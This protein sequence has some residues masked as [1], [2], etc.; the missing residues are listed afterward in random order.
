MNKV[1]NAGLL[2]RLR[3]SIESTTGYQRINALFDAGSFNE[4]DCYARSGEN[5][6]E[7]ITGYGTIEGC[8]AFVFSQNRD[9]EG[10]AMSKAQASKIR[11]LY[12]LALKTGTPVI[13]IY[14]SIGGRL[15][16]G[17]DIFAAYGDVLANANELSGVVPQIS[18]V[19]GPCIGTSAMIAASADFIVMSDKGE[20]TIDTNGEKGSAD[21]AAKMG[22]C[23]ILAKDEQEAIVSV[24]KLITLLPSNNLSGIPVLEMQ[25]ISDETELNENSE[26]KTIL[27][28]VCD[29]DGFIELG[30]RFG[31]SSITGLAEID[32]STTG[33]VALSGVLDADSC[34][35]AARFIRFCDAFSLPIVT[36]V[37]AEKFA[38][39][40][41]ASKLSSSYS[42]AT[43]GKITVITGSAYGPVYIAVAGRGANSDYTMAW[44]N[45]VVS[46]LAPETAAVFLWNDRLAGSE[47]PV[48]DRK[49]LIE[50]YKQTEASPFAVA[51]DGYIEDI[52]KPEDTRIRVIT[53]LQMLS[54]K[55]VSG[56][57]KK[58]SNIQI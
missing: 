19:L 57:S 55:R 5:L 3:D 52:I 34:T 45:A 27:T 22:I 7:V 53:N 11:K 9:I 26:I 38:S 41:E 43:T 42:E 49:K 14:D 28:A 31:S 29:D 35:K 17:S 48:E 2:H 44:P 18:L 24:R 30:D 46:P 16:E 39:L 32:G 23:H 6:A 8:P 4:L 1:D 58:H 12:N 15:K 50:E 25:V 20:L 47:N 40:R 13:G 21:E 54:E 33:I 37:N 51:A 56:L 36:F 10:G